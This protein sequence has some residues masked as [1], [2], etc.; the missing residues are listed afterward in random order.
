M[1]VVVWLLAA[2]RVFLND[3]VCL[4]FGVCCCLMSACYC[5]VYDGCWFCVIDVRFLLS[6]VCWL[7]FLCVV[8]VLLVL[9]LVVLRCC[10]LLLVVVV[11][12]VFDDCLR[13]MC[14]V[15]CLLVA[16]RC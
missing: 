9:L 7:L 3:V 4:V 10:L 2:A 14:G 13:L 12:F 5:D 1:C 15:F 8:N 11:C 16:V 6:Y